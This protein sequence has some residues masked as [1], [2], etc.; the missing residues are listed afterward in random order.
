MTDGLVGRQQTTTGPVPR[1]RLV[2]WLDDATTRPVTVV[3][4]PAGSGKTVLLRTWATGAS[5]P[6]A[7]VGVDRHMRDAQAFWSTVVASLAATLPSARFSRPTPTPDFDGTTAVARLVTELAAVEGPVVL[8]VDDV[9]ELSSAELISQ[10]ETLIELLPAGLHLLLAGRAE[11]AL[12]LHRRRLAGDLS[13]LPAV[14]LHFTL[15]ETQQLLS[16]VGGTLSCTA[17]RTLHER[18]EGWAAGLRL[19]A[20][21]LAGAPDPEIF[22]STFS[23]SERTVADYLIAEV[24]DRQPSPVR[25]LLLRTSILDSV[26]GPLA[27]L[28]T[29]GSGGE[30]MLRSLE[31]AGTFVVAAESSRS[32]FRYHRLFADLLMLE[33][34]RTEPE[35]VLEAISHARSAGEVSLAIEVLS[36]HY[37]GLVLDGR[38]GTAHEALA[39]IPFDPASAEP[40]LAVL[41]AHDELWHGSLEAAGQFV[42][43]A[44][45]GQVPQDNRHRFDVMLAVARL[46]LARRRGDFASVRDLIR[47]PE[48]ASGHQSWGDVALDR[49]LH[50]VA[51][52][53][54]GIV[55]AWSGHH[56]AGALH[57]EQV[58][59]LARRS[60]RRYVEIAAAAN[61]GVTLSGQSFFRAEAACRAAMSLAAGEG[62][63]G[64]AVVAP[65]LVV[66]AS[67]LMQTGRFEEAQRTLDDASRVVNA[68]VD[69]AVAYL[70]HA[71][72]GGLHLVHHD[73]ERA[74]SSYDQAQLL[75]TLL[76]NAPPL[77]LHIRCM[78]L[79]AHLALGR[80]DAVLDALRGMDD[81]DRDSGEAR[82]VAAEAAL[83]A[84]DPVGA[85]S[86]VAQIL[87]GSA[88]VHHVS[89][90]IRASLVAALASDALQDRA[91]VEMAIE[92]AL[93]LAEPDGLMLP[94]FLIDTGRLLTDH[95]RHR[96]AHPTFLA[97]L[98]DQVAGVAP[99]PRQVASVPALSESE[100]HVLRYLPSH[101][102][103]PEIASEM[104]LSV[105]TIK[106]HMR[107]IYA[108]LD[109]HNRADAVRQA[110]DLGLLSPRRR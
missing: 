49:D 67:S 12:S 16:G 64:E 87:D 27:D 50:M 33:L 90:V 61:R 21:L 95:P 62:W 10:L 38:E 14:D 63:A 36:R 55:E 42:V 32:W 11:P 99:L 96:T 57:L 15:D 1:E 92:R 108:K 8:V 73:A 80:K 35:V 30:A 88:P 60:S 31:Q 22:V 34:Q 78:I 65:A 109:V 6:V 25:A 82:T 43:L 59:D 53:N 102:G 20:I 51:L 104:F 110:R 48:Q 4:G 37:F 98:L 7:W 2:R 89:M 84:G 40:Q 105:H 83:R 72:Q 86:V 68:A 47:S 94:F 19:A 101:L 5:T 56:D 70:L 45:R 58:A 71:V 93:D 77:A 79:H 85:L 66:L 91:A 18:T 28:L 74:R 106:T 54:L 13:E 46:S 3:T 107:H 23:G 44:G 69:P 26:S 100:L 17:L 29:G 24:L 52:L 103:A 39:S 75:T 9:H 81:A 97:Q 41:L 76:V